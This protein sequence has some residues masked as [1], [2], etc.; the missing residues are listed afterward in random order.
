MVEAVWRFLNGMWL[1]MRHYCNKS[2]LDDTIREI[3][4]GIGNKYVINFVH[5]A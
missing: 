4:D 3:L 5:T 1:P 2:V